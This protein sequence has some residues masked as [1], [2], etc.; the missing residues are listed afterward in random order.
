MIMV[1]HISNLNDL[2]IELETKITYHNSKD[3]LIQEAFIVWYMLTEGAPSSPYSEKDLLR[4]LKK[5][6]E[7][8][9]QYYTNDTDYSFITG[10]MMNVAFWHFRTS[11]DEDY[12]NQLLLKAYH[13]APHNSLFKWSVRQDLG[14][15]N[16]EVGRLQQDICGQFY[17]YYN[18]GEVIRNYFVGVVGRI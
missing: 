9:Q 17:Q 2:V 16:H 11:F 8:Y 6:F 14:L 7:T 15:N 13:H 1:D 12:G 10:W 18:Y 4:L 5:N 3:L